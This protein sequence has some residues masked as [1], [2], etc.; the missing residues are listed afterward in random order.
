[1][2]DS[3]ETVLGAHMN[4]ETMTSLTLHSGYTKS[5]QREVDMK[6]QKLF[7]GDTCWEIESKFASVVTVGILATLQ[8][9]SNTQK[10]LANKMDAIDFWF[11]CCWCY[12]LVVFVWYFVFLGCWAFVKFC[13]FWERE[14]RHIKLRRWG[15]YGKTWGGERRWSKCIMKEC[16]HFKMWYKNL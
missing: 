1:M 13:L 7:A 3:K 6:S 16:K 2:D 5:Q 12:G 14:G 8:G 4:P 9:R 15:G 11:C 10:Q